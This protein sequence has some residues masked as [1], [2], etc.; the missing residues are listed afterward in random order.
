[1]PLPIIA[2]AAAAAAL[3]KTGVGVANNIKAKKKAKQL[4]ANRPVLPPSQYA[5]DSLSLAESEL[6]GSDNQ[7]T[8]A[9]EDANDRALSSSLGVLQKSGG[10][11]NNV[12]EIFD[13]SNRGRL[14]LLMI[15]ENIRQNNIERVIR[16]GQQADQDRLQGFQYNQY[17][18]WA[19]QSQANAL[20][21]ERSSE[22]IT[23]GVSTL[24]S[25]AGAIAGEYMNY[26]GNMG[27]GGRRA[28]RNTTVGRNAQPVSFKQNYNSPASRV[29]QIDPNGFGR[30]EM[31]YRDPFEF[32]G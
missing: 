29:N 10:T 16:A 21:R 4:A 1:M 26:D 24:F 20:A 23:E 6:A 31:N 17:G 5:K 32:E 28:P 15:K 19:D 3:I 9:Y 27:G 18:P 8:R 30:W 25:A 12:A 14:Q 22:E 2:I 13:N 7:A 11:P